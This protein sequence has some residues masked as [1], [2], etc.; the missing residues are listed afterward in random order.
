MN[1]NSI[2]TKCMHGNNCILR[3]A[4][5]P[6]LIK[7]NKVLVDQSA[8]C[9]EWV[10]VGLFEFGVTICAACQ[11]LLERGDHVMEL[12]GRRRFSVNKCWGCSE[13][14]LGQTLFFV[15]HFCSECRHKRIE[16]GRRALWDFI[17]MSGLADLLI[18]K[19]DENVQVESAQ[20][21]YHLTMM[22]YFGDSLPD[23]LAIFVRKEMKTSTFVNN[24]S[25]K[26]IR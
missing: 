17:E 25:G 3:P 8:H 22:G 24:F 14:Q 23:N 18:E 21:L 11:N 1:T 26:I 10:A 9:D 2:E 7:N 13:V 16:V 5:T 15:P 6:V 12:R 19:L 20:D 4:Y